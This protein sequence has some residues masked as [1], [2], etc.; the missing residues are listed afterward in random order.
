[1]RAGYTGM[2]TSRAT[3]WHT[4]LRDRQWCWRLTHN[5]L[6]LLLDTSQ[7]MAEH[8]GTSACR[9]YRLLVPWSIHPTAMAELGTSVGGVSRTATVEILTVWWASHG[10]CVHGIVSSTR[11]ATSGRL[12]LSRRWRSIGSSSRGGGFLLLVLSLSLFDNLFLFS[13]IFRQ[14]GD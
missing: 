2:I 4:G 10:S 3:R 12:L 11:G 6:S 5:T 1:M 9:V 7:T 14:D 13:R 8:P